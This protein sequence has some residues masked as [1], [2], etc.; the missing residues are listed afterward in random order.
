MIKII[1]YND[2]YPRILPLLYN[3]IKYPIVNY[4]LI[5]INLEKEYNQIIIDNIKNYESMIKWELYNK[6]EDGISLNQIQDVDNLNLIG[7]IIPIKDS[8][9]KII[10]NGKSALGNCYFVKADIALSSDD[11]SSFIPTDYINQE[12]WYGAVVFNKQDDKHSCIQIGDF[13][14]SISNNEFKPSEY[15]YKLIDTNVTNCSI[16]N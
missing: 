16:S 6:S 3:L 14:C 5:I 2:S 9:Q 12:P 15:K 11:Y 1:V 10:E 13:I 4:K 8:L 7:N